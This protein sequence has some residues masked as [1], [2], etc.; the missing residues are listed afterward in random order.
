MSA[1]EIH[2]KADKKHR[3]GSTAMRAKVVEARKRQQERF[4]GIHLQFN[5][6]M[7]VKELERLV[8]LGKKEQEFMDGVYEKL[9]LSLRSYH[10]ILKVA[11]TIADLDASEEIAMKHL[12]EALCY[13][14]VEERYWG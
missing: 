11:R 10:R 9:H 7:G 2:G 4:A 6:Q 8:T 5:S 14:S 1:E 12:Q 13:R 3:Y